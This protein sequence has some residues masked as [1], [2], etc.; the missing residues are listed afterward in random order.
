MYLPMR[1]SRGHAHEIPG[2]SGGTGT[3]HKTSFKNKTLFGKPMFMRRIHRARLHPN[4][5]SLG[6]Q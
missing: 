4:Q 2:E 6:S 5:Q 3:V 1:A